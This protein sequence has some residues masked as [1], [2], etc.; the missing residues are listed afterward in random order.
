MINTMI[1]DGYLKLSRSD[2]KKTMGL[3]LWLRS[4]A[5]DIIFAGAWKAHSV[6]WRGR[7]WLL[8][9][10]CHLTT[11][12]EVGARYNKSKEAVRK[13]LQKLQSKRLI[14]VR[15]LRYSCKKPKEW[16]IGSGP[17]LI[18]GGIQ[19]EVKTEVDASGAIF[20]PRS[21]SGIRHKG[22]RILL[23]DIVTDARFS[24]SFRMFKNERILVFRSQCATVARE[25]ASNYGVDHSTILRW[26]KSLENQDLLDFEAIASGIEENAPSDAPSKRKIGIIVTISNYDTYQPQKRI[27]NNDKLTDRL[28]QQKEGISET[29]KNVEDRTPMPPKGIPGYDPAPTFSEK[30]RN[31]NKLTPEI[32]RD[33]WYEMTDPLYKQYIKHDRFMKD[34]LVPRQRRCRRSKYL[35]DTWKNYIRLCKRFNCSVKSFRNFMEIFIKEIYFPYWAPYVLSSPTWWLKPTAGGQDRISLLMYDDTFTKPADVSSYKWKNKSFR[36]HCRGLRETFAVSEST[37]Q[38]LPRLF[39]IRFLPVQKFSNLSFC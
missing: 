35:R 19:I 34:Q 7:T 38:C 3:P 2:W 28:T 6:E 39:A 32:L 10:G 37:V 21:V 13:G 15:N 11:L 12:S 1:Q 26:L 18:I 9:V 33:L 8:N 27:S 16:T 17:G 25:I 29:M 30:Q 23:V 31:S 24:A 20:L 36:S 5:L 4:L 22:H 14:E